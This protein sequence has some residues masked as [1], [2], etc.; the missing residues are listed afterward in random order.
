M[1]EQAGAAGR[2]APAWALAAEFAGP[3]VA[4][5]VLGGAGLSPIIIS[6]HG[7]EVRVLFGNFVVPGRS[8]MGKVR[9]ARATDDDASQRGTAQRGAVQRSAEQNSEAQ[10]SIQAGVQSKSNGPTGASVLSL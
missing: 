1:D 8:P 9:P 6:L 3:R 5:R 2:R 10:H 4:R 7:L